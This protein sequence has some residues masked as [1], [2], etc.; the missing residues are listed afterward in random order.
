MLKVSLPDYSIIHFVLYL[1][2]CDVMAT[3]PHLHLTTFLARL[4]T[5]GIICVFFSEHLLA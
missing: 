2:P 1:A 3:Y 5:E 4:R